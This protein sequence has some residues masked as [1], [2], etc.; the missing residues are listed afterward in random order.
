MKLESR[1]RKYKS[2]NFQGLDQTLTKMSMGDSVTKTFSNSELENQN[3]RPTILPA[4]H[5]AT[6]E[7]TLI[8]KK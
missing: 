5:D 2:K 8:D 4:G 6:F 1:N 3:G 7:I